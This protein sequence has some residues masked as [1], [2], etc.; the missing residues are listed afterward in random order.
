MP[1]FKKKNFFLQSI[2]SVLDQTY[3][4]IEVLIVYDDYNKEDLSYIKNRINKDSRVKI[5]I[6]DKNKP[7]EYY[8][9]NRIVTVYDKYQCPTYCEVDHFHYVYFDSLMVN[10]GNMCIDKDK[11]GKRYKK[12]V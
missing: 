8:Y 10:H 9:E 11:L 6:N 7:K 3:S 4:N 5:F 2:K 12:D 1:Y